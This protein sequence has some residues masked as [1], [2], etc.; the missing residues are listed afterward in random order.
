MKKHLLCA[1]LLVTVNSQAQNISFG[2]IQTPKEFQKYWGLTPE[3]MQQYEQYMQ[4]AGKY[5]HQNSNPLVVLSI[6][7]KDPEDKNYYAAKAATYEHKMAKNEIETA[8]LMSKEMERQGLT[9]AMTKFSDKLTGISSDKK[10]DKHS[11][12]KDDEVMIVVD[13]NCLKVNCLPTFVPLLSNLPNDT[14][15]SV[16]NNSKQPIATTITAL[17][18]ALSSKK[19]NTIIVSSSNYDPIEHG[20]LEAI[21]NQA[22]QVRNG[23]IIRKL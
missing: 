4:V 22:V 11:W 3:Q 21:K 20:Y 8:W 9:E 10:T 14:K 17:N 2:K 19:N 16:I 5:R 13:E 6:I 18:K 7:S 1:L 12:E 15:V 23:K